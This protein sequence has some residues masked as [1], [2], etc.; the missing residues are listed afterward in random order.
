MGSANEVIYQDLLGYSTEE[1]SQ[2][3][4]KGVI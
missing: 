4:E 3:K 2:M 1:I